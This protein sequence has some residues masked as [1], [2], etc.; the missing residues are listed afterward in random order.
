MPLKWEPGRN[1]YIHNYFGRLGLGPN[2]LPLQITE[3]AKNRRKKIVAGHKVELAG[4][5]LD[6]HAVSEASKELLRPRSLAEE[7]LLVH[8]Q[9]DHQRRK[10]SS[11]VDKIREEAVVAVDRTSPPLIHPIGIFWFTPLP[12]VGSL[13]L[14]DWTSFGLVG[15]GEAADVELDIIF[16]S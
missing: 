15:P 1:P 3:Q 2:A 8:P 16:D 12:Q 6:E 13:E 11:P 9:P 5:V 10:G 14:P 7:L 4:E